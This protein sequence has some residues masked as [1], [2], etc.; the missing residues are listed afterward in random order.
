MTL[1][2]KKQFG[3]IETQKTLTETRSTEKHKELVNPAEH[4]D[5]KLLYGRHPAYSKSTYAVQ[6]TS[7]LEGRDSS[8]YLEVELREKFEE[9]LKELCVF[10]EIS[11]TELLKVADYV[12]QLKIQGVFERVPDLLQAIEGQADISESQELYDLAVES[13]VEDL[14]A[15][16]TVTSDHYRHGV[17]SGVILDSDPLRRRFGSEVV[18]ITTESVYEI[19]GLEPSPQNKVRLQEVIKAWYSMGYIIK[20]SKDRWQE[21]F[22]PNESIKDAKRF[23]LLKVEG[24]NE[25]LNVEESVPTE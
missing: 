19:I 1:Q 5:I 18:G 23:Y 15:Y 24:L 13:I 22:R 2:R 17:S 21:A 16:P 14:A 6:F 11:R 20:R 12:K 9:H 4:F 8:C 25:H 10:G 3:V 7:R